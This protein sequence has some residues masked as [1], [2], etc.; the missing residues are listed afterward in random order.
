VVHSRGLGLVLWGRCL[1][2]AFSA[3]AISC[4]VERSGAPP[5]SL[6]VLSFNQD[7]KA[8][9]ALH[10]FTLL[11]DKD[12]CAQMD[13]ILAAMRSYHAGRLESYR[14]GKPDKILIFIHGGLNSQEKA[15]ERALEQTAPILSA[16]YYPI[17][18]NWDS[19]LL[20]SYGE[21]LLYVRQGEKQGIHL[22]TAPFYLFAD[23]GRAAARA[24]TVWAH[25]A[26]ENP[27]AIHARAESIRQQ[28][29][30]WLVDDA[31]LNVDKYYAELHRL[32]QLDAKCGPRRQIQISLG[33]ENTT[34]ATWL[35]DSASYALTL[36]TKVATA[37]LIDAL[38]RESWENMSRRTVNMF[39]DPAY[40]QTL[41][42]P[43]D[44]MQRLV[45]KGPP[46][47]LQKFMDRLKDDLKRRGDGHS[48][49]IT[50]VGHSMGTMVINQ[51]IRRNP[52]LNFKNIVYLAAACS[53]H[54]FRDSVVPYLKM[55]VHAQTRFFN[56]CLHPTAEIL[57][58]EASD[59]PPR[60]SLL[61][62]VD[63]FLAAPRTPLDRTLGQ[64]DNILA[65]TYIFDQELRGRVAI[66][67]F[68][69]FLKDQPL[70]ET[71]GDFSTC[72]YWDESFW[73]PLP[74]DDAELNKRI[75]Q[76][77]RRIS[78]AEH[79]QRHPPKPAKTIP[80]N[81]KKY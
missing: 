7:G 45:D 37:P 23:L 9:N 57:D 73:T 31:E 50:V 5:V 3:L 10:D 80:D 24:P 16:G 4:Q 38:G 6:H 40:V 63:Q 13:A 60:G 49:E 58:A 43:P 69:L 12:Y 1:L 25:L 47:D 48:F 56:L 44:V 11:K 74:A 68:A 36:P 70:Q 18:V 8:V 14:P 67:G 71:H 22:L 33:P 17:F 41:G 75:D 77:Q 72:A 20:S 27:P 52:D 55:P 2:I 76:M 39:E 32:Y 62:W 28:Q 53:I 21:H 34:R 79:T 15:L 46:G 35:R 65:A 81:V 59:I 26:F 64:W 42:Q 30:H 78:E 51:M 29:P 19:E 66:K 61:V 54:D